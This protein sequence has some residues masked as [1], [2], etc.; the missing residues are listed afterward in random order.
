MY[1]ADSTDPNYELTSATIIGVTFEMFNG[2]AIDVVATDKLTLTLMDVVWKV[3]WRI[4]I[5]EL[6]GTSGLSLW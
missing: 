1:L 2:T 3:S 6:W 5:V 4:L